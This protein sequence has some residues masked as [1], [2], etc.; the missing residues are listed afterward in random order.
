MQ[1]VGRYLS[2]LWAKRLAY[3]G[4]HH[5]RSTTTEDEVLR[6]SDSSANAAAARLFAYM[7]KPCGK[8]YESRREMVDTKTGYFIAGAQRPNTWQLQCLQRGRLASPSYFRWA[9]RAFYTF[10]PRI[11]V[12][13]P[14]ATNQTIRCVFSCRAT[15]GSAKVS[16]PGQAVGDRWPRPGRGLSSRFTPIPSSNEHIL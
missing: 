3:F 1:K 15:S 14:E 5:T 4:Q 16:R 10:L 9:V 11:R 2:N 12:T 7:N 8:A 13:D 6:G